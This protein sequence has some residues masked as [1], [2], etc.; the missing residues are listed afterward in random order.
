MSRL[1]SR[2]VTRSSASAI[3]RGV[4]VK[5]GRFMAVRLPHRSSVVSAARR[6]PSIV[7]CGE[8]S[9]TGVSAGTGHTAASPATGSRMMLDRKLEAAAFGVPGLAR[10]GHQTN[11]AR[12]HEAPPTVVRHK[13]LAE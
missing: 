13:L 10:Y 9:A 11:S 8:E 4:V 7:R 5:D 12:G 2:P 6:M 1:A 3:A